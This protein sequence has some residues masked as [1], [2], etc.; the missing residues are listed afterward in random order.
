MGT[1]S[2]GY[3]DD[4][5]VPSDASIIYVTADNIN[6]VKAD[7]I[8]NAKGTKT[9]CTGLVDILSKRQKGYD[10]SHLIIRVIGEI[11]ASDISGLNRSGYLQFKGCYN[12][13]LEGIGEYATVNGWG[14]LIRGARNFE[15]RNLEVM[16]F[17]DDAISL[18]TD[19]QNIWIH[20][21]DIFYGTA[22]SDAD[23]A[24]GDGSCDVKSKSSYVTV[25]YNHFVDSGK[26]SLCGMS[27]SEE[28][29]VTY[30]HNWFDHSDSRHPRIRVGS[31]HIYNNYFDGN[32]KYGVGV[33]KG[34][35]A[36]VEA[37]D[38][39]NCKHPMLT[40][41]QGTDIAGNSKG[42]FSGEPGGMIK[43]YNNK[44]TGGNKVIYA[45]ENNSQFDAYNASSRNE[46]VPDYYKTIS[47]NNTYNNFD[48]S[49]KFYKYNPDSPDEVANKVK[50]YTGRING[51]DFKWTFTDADDESS[52][53][54]KDLMAK[55]K[56][57]KSSLVSIGGNSIK[58]NNAH[59]PENPDV[60]EKPATPEKPDIPD[61]PDIPMNPDTGDDANK[62]S[63]IEHNF[64]T[65]GTDSSFF[66][67]NGKLSNDRNGLNYN[68]LTLT[69]YLKFEKRTNISFTTEKDCNLK[70]VFNSDFSKNV[71][72][73]G[74]KHKAINGIVTLKL[75]S[76]T[77]T[78][79]KA[80][81]CSLYY[82]SVEQ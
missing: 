18:D 36:F 27:D 74:V 16:L 80:D 73:D 65:S 75:S 43:A 62:E 78:I 56:S 61:T 17:P 19:N 52:S 4:G 69:K 72:I 10:K 50:S 51:D 57:Y 13:T 49:P 76:G 33:T 23:Q 35:S 66:K 5:S 11:K 59:N 22:G 48:I 32:A 21:N 60:P 45:K 31:V 14:I 40:S 68:N 28:F 46:S 30:H 67:I 64:T 34:A 79:T 63:T 6:T 71:T 20:N 41:L 47:G 39:R 26:C 38:F 37:N 9:T 1:G 54:N 7:V 77:H 44:I 3:N 70:L 12:V 42:T 8:S 24:K 2:G 81:K 58:D 82:I 25:S 53:L 55:I 15:V 29:F